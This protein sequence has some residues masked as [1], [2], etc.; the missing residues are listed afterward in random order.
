MVLVDRLSAMQEKE[1]IE[2][3]LVCLNRKVILKLQ[4]VVSVISNSIRL[5]KLLAPQTGI[6]SEGF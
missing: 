1:P 3:S 6:Y 2:K 4:D 5:A